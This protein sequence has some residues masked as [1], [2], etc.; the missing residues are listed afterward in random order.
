MCSGLLGT[1]VNNSE[2]WCLTQASLWDSDFWDL[3]CGVAFNTFHASL[4][5][6]PTPDHFG[7]WVGSTYISISWIMYIYIYRYVIYISYFCKYV[8]LEA[9]PPCSMQ[10]NWLLFYF[11][12]AQQTAEKRFENDELDPSAPV[13]QDFPFTKR[14]RVRRWGQPLCQSHES[15]I[16][17]GNFFWSAATCSLQSAHVCCWGKR[18]LDLWQNLRRFVFQW[19]LWPQ[20]GIAQLQL[21][22]LGISNAGT[23]GTTFFLGGLF[24]SV[25]ALLP[26]QWHVE[27][28]PWACWNSGHLESLGTFWCSV[29]WCFWLIVAS[30]RDKADCLVCK[31][32]IR[33]YTS[34]C[35]TTLFFLWRLTQAI[36]WSREKNE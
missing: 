21:L 13:R 35:Y 10:Q 26:R 8:G 11:S 23:F 5:G 16:G 15:W 33:V 30:T 12:K 24:R 9:F 18:G 3:S 22:D 32:I 6:C 4:L 28:G 29:R 19:S 34:V 25:K 17:N 31:C 36:L 20:A 27:S 7:S 1:L 14:M 2:R